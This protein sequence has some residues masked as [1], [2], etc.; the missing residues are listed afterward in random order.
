MGKVCTKC[1]E[2]KP[3]DAFYENHQSP[4]NGPR[5]I[6]KG[7]MKIQRDSWRMQNR[8][9]HL[10]MQTEYD[11]KIRHKVLYFY[12]NGKMEC[13]CCGETENKFLTLD[14]I[15]NDGAEHRRNT[16]GHTFGWLIR[17][18]MPTGFQVLCMNCNFAKGKYGECPHETRRRN[19][20]RSGTCTGRRSQ[21]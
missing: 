2:G 3:I 7:C 9:R 18:G 16:K 10:K 14:H 17:N 20:R 8:S 4:S 6:C 5:S 21:V 12:S 1:G 13:G 11:R 15:N 19:G